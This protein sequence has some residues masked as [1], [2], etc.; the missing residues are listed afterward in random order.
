MR[1]LPWWF[2]LGVGIVKYWYMTI[3]LA[4]ALALAAILG[5]RLTGTLQP[6]K[7]DGNAVTHW[8][9]DLHG[10]TIIDGLPC[11][12]GPYAN[13]RFGGVLFDTNGKIHRLTLAAP[14]ELLGLKLPPNTT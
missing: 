12:G 10:Y 13:D 9:G 8:G 5:M 1:G 11:K 14:H 7:R 6:W 4:I 3:P 2:W